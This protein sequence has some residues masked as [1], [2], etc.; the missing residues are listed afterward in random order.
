VAIVCERYDQIESTLPYRYGYGLVEKTP[1]VIHSRCVEMPKVGLE[2][3][4]YK[5][6]KMTR[7]IDDIETMQYPASKAI[8][9]PQHGVIEFDQ[10][11]FRIK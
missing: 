11:Q 10:H 8:A 5:A 6:V 1:L 9:I 2:M 3:P 4:L 7:C